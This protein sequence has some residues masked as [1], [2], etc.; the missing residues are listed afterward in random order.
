LL[1]EQVVKGCMAKSPDD[2]FQTAHDVKLQLKWIGQNANQI[3]AAT[4]PGVRAR[5]HWVAWSAI[6]ALL[7]ALVGAGA[8]GWWKAA[9]TPRPV[10]RATMMPPAGS[11]FALLNRNG[12]PAFSP[13]GKR[14]AFIA[15]RG[16]KTSLWVRSLDKMEA[17]ELPDRRGIFSFLVTRRE[18]HRVLCQRKARA[19]GFEWW[20]SGH[21]L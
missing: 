20:A 16:G 21:D 17:V 11:E 2:R 6:G 15:S 18:L 8:M 19:R 12:P 9:Q 5:R 7:L 10:I 4:A 1:L 13:D 14:V 3:A